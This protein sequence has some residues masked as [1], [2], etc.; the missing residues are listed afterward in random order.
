VNFFGRSSDWYHFHQAANRQFALVMEL[1][2][3]L[4]KEEAMASI[5]VASNAPVDSVDTGSKHVE[6]Q[7]GIT[8]GR[9]G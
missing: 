4:K 2:K 7:E 8:F 9:F 1:T 6:P 5:P 3:E